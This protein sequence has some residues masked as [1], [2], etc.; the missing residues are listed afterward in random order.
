MALLSPATHASSE[1]D[2]V[3]QAAASTGE[4][5]RWVVRLRQW[6]RAPLAGALIVAIFVA[7]AIFA[8]LLA[9]HNPNYQFADGLTD[10]GEPLPPGHSKFVLGTDMLGRD[11]LSRLIYGS[12]VAMFIATVPNLLALALA[13]AVGTTAGYFGAAIETVLMRVTE[14]IMVL[15]TFLLVLALIAVLGPGLT[16]VVAALVLVSWTYPARVIFGETVRIRELAFVEAARSL[17]ATNRRIIIR[18]ILPQI[19]GILIIYFSLN[20]AWMVLLE[21][22]LGF[23]GFGIQPPTP[24]WGLMIASGRDVLFWPWIMLLPGVCLALLGAGFYLIGAGAQQAF[25]TRLTRVHL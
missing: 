7:C 22:G 13:A 21:A 25:G 10:L 1:T 16:V 6:G 12:R 14:T 17:G 15:P 18:H 11:M 8:P 2:A 24:S 9:P 5:F 23:L 19:R 3:G 20:A 4:R